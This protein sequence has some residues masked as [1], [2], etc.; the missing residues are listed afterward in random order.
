[1]ET[2]HVRSTVH[3]ASGINLLLGLWLILAPFVLGY[4]GI[5]ES[6]WNDIV[7]GAIIA[8]LAAIRIFTPL[9]Y[10]SLSWWN[11]AL[12]GWLIFAPFLIYGAGASGPPAQ[13]ATWNEVIVGVLVIV[14]GAWSAL[15]TRSIRP[16]EPD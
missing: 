14:L 10:R 6:L 13:A 4:S 8:I 7:I 2:G 1:M 12:G 11:F 16:T 3:W 5:R 9:Q 15:S